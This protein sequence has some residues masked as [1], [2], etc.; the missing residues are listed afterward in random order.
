MIMCIYICYIIH[1]CFEL[2]WFKQ[3]IFQFFSIYITKKNGFSP[4]KVDV[5]SLTQ[6]FQWP[7]PTARAVHICPSC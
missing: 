3:H 4:G 7:R 6:L 5:F 2:L 1:I